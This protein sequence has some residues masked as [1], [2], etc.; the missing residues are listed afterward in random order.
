MLEICDRDQEE[1]VVI[2]IFPSYRLLNSAMICHI[3]LV[4]PHVEICA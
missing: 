2:E 3:L 4:L 1:N